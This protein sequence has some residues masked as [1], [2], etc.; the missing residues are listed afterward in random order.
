MA[1]TVVVAL[2]RL[3]VMQGALVGNAA[4]ARKQ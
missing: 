3:Y 2:L 4:Y 1:V